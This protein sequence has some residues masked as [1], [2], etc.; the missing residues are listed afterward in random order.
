VTSFLSIR[1]SASATGAYNKMSSSGTESTASGMSQSDLS[2]E[3]ELG[4]VCGEVRYSISL[5]LWLFL[6]I[7]MVL[8]FS[9]STACQGLCIQ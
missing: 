7:L 4:E 3:Q 8:N 5:I 1:F 6:C 9:V 2:H